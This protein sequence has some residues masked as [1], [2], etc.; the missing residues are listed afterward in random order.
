MSILEVRP[1]FVTSSTIQ[2]FKSNALFHQA[3]NH[4]PPGPIHPI[5]DLSS[6][7]SL[8]TGAISSNA[9]AQAAANRPQ[10]SQTPLQWHDGGG[11]Y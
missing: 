8:Q 2:A 3:S 11:R 4:M 7:R 9:A 6:F 5:I 10:A 1:I